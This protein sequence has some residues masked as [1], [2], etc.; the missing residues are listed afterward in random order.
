[1]STR[2]VLVVDDDKDLRD[3][4]R[5]FLESAGYEV[6]TLRDG[7]EALER[8]GREPR[9]MMMLLDLT[10]PGMSGWDVLARLRA[11]PSRPSVP[12]VAMTAMGDSPAGPLLGVA[13][14]LRKPFSLDSMLA[15]IRDHGEL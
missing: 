5:D 11:D 14:V 4:L 13:R 3:I 6:E 10:M 15:A 8:L 7:R 12:V 1:V 2:P 9:P